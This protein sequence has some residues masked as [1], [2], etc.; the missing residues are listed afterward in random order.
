MPP[1]CLTSPRSQCAT[2]PHR[3]CARAHAAS[4][5]AADLQGKKLTPGFLLLAMHYTQFNFYPPLFAL[6]LD[7]GK[8]AA[9]LVQASPASKHVQV[10]LTKRSTEVCATR[11]QLSRA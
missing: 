3:L 11:R 10:L 1:R 9:R 5:I 7:N 8:L 4:C 2:T 6:Q